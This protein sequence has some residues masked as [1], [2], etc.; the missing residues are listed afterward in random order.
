M[1]GVRV[2]LW[3]SSKATAVWSRIPKP[4]AIAN[5]IPQGERKYLCILGGNE[6]SGGF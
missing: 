6:S 3:A 1:I 5:I 2:A 4:W